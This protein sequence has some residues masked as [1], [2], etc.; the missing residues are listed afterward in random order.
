MGL[1]STDQRG[2]RTG[3]SSGNIVMTSFSPQ[4]SVRRMIVKRDA[5]VVYDAPF[6]PGLNIVRGENSSGK[7]TI[8]DFLFYGL[9]GDLSDWREAALACSEV[10]LEGSLNGHSA[11]LAREI[12]E[13]SGRP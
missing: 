5:A 13:S 9:G 6:H 12:S 1:P 11:V 10:T 3:R 2:S 7:S 4:L 8:L